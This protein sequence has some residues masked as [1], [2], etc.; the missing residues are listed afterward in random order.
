MCATANQAGPKRQPPIPPSN[1]LR[2][3]PYFFKVFTL[4]PIYWGFVHSLFMGVL[5][6]GVFEAMWVNIQLAGCATRAQGVGHS[7]CGGVNP[8]GV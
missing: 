4:T 8:G 2:F 3:D 5:L 6:G 7:L 1:K